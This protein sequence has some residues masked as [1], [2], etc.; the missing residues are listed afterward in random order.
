[1]SKTS[2]AMNSAT[3]PATTRQKYRDLLDAVARGNQT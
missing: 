1:M 2:I 3:P